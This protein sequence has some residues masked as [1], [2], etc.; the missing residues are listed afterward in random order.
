MKNKIL[1]FLIITS[2]IGCS[3]TNKKIEN[4]KGISLFKVN[5][6]Y[7]SKIDWE[8]VKTGDVLIQETD[9]NFL[10]WF[11]HCGI[12]VSKGA[13]AEIPKLGESVYCRDINDWKKLRRV[14]LLR[15]KNIN[16]E[17]RTNLLKKIKESIGKKY[18][19][20]SKK[21]SKY[22]YCSQYI[23]D[24]YYEAGKMSNLKIDIDSNGGFMVM[25][26]ELLESDEFEIIDI[27]N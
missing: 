9:G 6:H 17:L 21:N 18:F 19:I 10:G 25:P 4:W 8:K 16:N 26:Y 12:V 22:F 7:D 5:K 3:G 20:V 13:V 2:I 14:A 11:G 15:Y 27:M 23:W 1:I 24:I